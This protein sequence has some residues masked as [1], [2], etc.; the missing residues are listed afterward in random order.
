M[1]SIWYNSPGSRNLFPN[2]T[3]RLPCAGPRAAARSKEASP[4]RRP[5]AVIFVAS[6]TPLPHAHAQQP[7]FNDHADV[8][9]YRRWHL[10]ANNEY[11]LL[12]RSSYPNFRQDTQT[13]KFS[14]GLFRSC[15]VGMDFPLL[16]IFNTR[17]SGLGSPF[18][19]GDADF[20]IKY[21]FRK[22]HRISIAWGHG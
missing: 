1:L 3:R 18:G 19:L 11:D 5:L 21:D 13:I 12:R 8:V 20:S 9:T 14:C 2:G 17:G 4:V 22:E 7:F 16:T 6:L 15:E 10:K